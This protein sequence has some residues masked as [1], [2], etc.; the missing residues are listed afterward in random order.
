MDALDGGH[1]GYD[2][3][4]TICLECLRLETEYPRSIDS[5]SK[6]LLVDYLYLQ[7]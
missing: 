7:N 2:V 3:K 5:T 6:V 1:T 4:A